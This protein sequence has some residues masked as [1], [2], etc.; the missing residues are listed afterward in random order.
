MS[1]NQLS[2]RFVAVS[3]DSSISIGFGSFSALNEVTLT[4]NVVAASA[5]A[6]VSA[7]QVTSTSTSAD[8]EV[9]V[10][11]STELVNV[12]AAAVL[13]KSPTRRRDRNCSHLRSLHCHSLVYRRDPELNGNQ[14][15][16]FIFHFKKK[17]NE[18]EREG[19]MP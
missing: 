17:R 2:D 9:A 15:N 4:L 1:I 11:C 14:S 12:P 13:L 5:I 18:R 3:S 8:T 10:Q 16:C 6:I 7:C 19:R